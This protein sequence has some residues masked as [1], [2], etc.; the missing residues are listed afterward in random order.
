M[1]DSLLFDRQYYI[2]FQYNINLFLFFK[3]SE[4]LYLSFFDTHQKVIRVFFRG[5]RK[6]LCLQRHRRLYSRV[7]FSTYHVYQ[8]YLINHVSWVRIFD[9][10][11]WIFF[12]SKT[13]MRRTTIFKTYFTIMW[14]N[15]P[16]NDQK[17]ERGLVHFKDFVFFDKAPPPHP[18]KMSYE[19]TARD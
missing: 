7:K 8:L 11:I 2:H 17:I 4:N 1:I 16:L 10:L 9:W 6:W 18:I 5:L 14:N 19:R 12:F 3:I 13:T 15:C